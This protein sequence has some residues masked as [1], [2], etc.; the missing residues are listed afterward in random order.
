MRRSLFLVAAAS[1]LVA[2]APASARPEKAVA[3][4]ANPLIDYSGFVAL[5]KQVRPY[6]ARRLLGVA[7]F[8]ARAAEPRALLLD[9]RSADA[10]RQGHIEG[11]I[12]LPFTDFTADS[13]AQ[14]VGPDRT[15]PIYIY[16][17]NNFRNNVAPVMTKSVQLALNIQTF[18]NLVGYGYK[19]VW[20]LG[21]AVD[22]D[23]PAIGWVRG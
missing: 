4:A 1:C 7:D 8:R 9:A 6:R 13:L 3:P 10:F 21:E 23:D 15:R 19:E 17:N 2:A 22:M 5:T 18:V 16:C 20:E 14:V 11:A 12:N